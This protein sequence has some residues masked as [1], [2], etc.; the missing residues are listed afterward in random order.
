MKNVLSYA[1]Y[2]ARM[3]NI[4]TP[5]DA[6]AF[7]KEMMAPDVGEVAESPVAEKPKE[8]LKSVAHP[9]MSRTTKKFDV[10][11]GPW[12][13]IVNNENEA[14]VITLYA[15]GMTT[16]DIASYMKL[17]HGM[18]ITQPGV[19]AITD[20]V[21]PLVKEWQSRPLSTCYPIVYMDGLHFKVRE[22]GKISPKVAYIALGINAYGMREVL[23]IWVSDTEGAKFWLHVLNDM[24][25]RGVE[26]ILFACVDGLRGFPEAIKS[27]FPLAEVQACIV[28]QIRH[29]IMFIPHKYKEQFCND[30]KEVYSA[31]SEDAG[32]KSLKDLQ[33]KWP[34]FRSY[35]KS[36]EDR[37]SDLVP[38]FN[39][40]QQVRRMIY[41]T[42][43]I[44][45]LN[46]QFRKVTKTT[47]VFP[48][49]DALVKLLWLAQA[50]ITQNWTMTVRNWGEI[51]AQ[52]TILFPDR[53]QF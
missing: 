25:N 44:E 8:Q 36:W 4:H 11:V 22:A 30:L 17:H 20:K 21:F 18:E 33:E 28:H 47:T 12:F 16:R 24:K 3:K 10:G 32:M 53:I 31:S 41:T 48:H 43:T 14:M 19:S 5:E 9:I 27:M 40:P 13:D 7:A 52:L 26:D 6:E 1:E 2:H 29:T 51:M 15:K 42:N 23:G 49:D 37:W 34:Q 38:F 35:L 45:N 46:R 50:D 39:Y